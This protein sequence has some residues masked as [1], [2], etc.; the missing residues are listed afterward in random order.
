[1]DAL[2]ALLGRGF[3]VSYVMGVPGADGTSC[4]AI[5]APRSTTRWR[6]ATSLAGGPRRSSRRGSNAK[7]LMDAQNR[8]RP[9]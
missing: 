2:L 5:R 8:I 3:G 1:M 4:S 9:R 7:G 6:C